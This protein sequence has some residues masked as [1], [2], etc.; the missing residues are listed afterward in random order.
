MGGQDTGFESLLYL[1]SLPHLLLHLDGLR[2]LPTP[3]LDETQDLWLFPSPEEGLRRAPLFTH[4]HHTLW[5]Q[6]LGL[7]DQKRGEKRV[8]LRGRWRRD[9]SLPGTC[10][11]V[12]LSSSGL[13]AKGGRERPKSSQ[14][15]WASQ[16]TRGMKWPS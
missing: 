7:I 8:N 14:N 2:D 3:P 6:M 13:A 12:R 9:R 10:P 15:R 16:G 5:S 1:S 4:H 11:N